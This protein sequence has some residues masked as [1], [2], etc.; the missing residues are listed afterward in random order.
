[1]TELEQLDYVKKYFEPLSNKDVEFVD[2]YLQVLFPA[3][4]GKP[5]DHVVFS[6]DGSG[7]DSNDRHYRLRIRAYSQNA[8]FDTE[9]GNNDGMVTKKE[10]KD[11]VQKY[12]DDG[13]NNRAINFECDGKW[14][15]P[16][17]NGEWNLHT[18]GGA[19]KP[20]TSSFGATRNG[21]ARNHQGFDI[22]AEVGTSLYACLDG[23]IVS[24]SPISGYGITIILKIDNVDDL[25]SAKNEYA[26]TYPGEI[27]NGPG[28]NLDGDIY[29]RYAHSESAT[30][31]VGDSV[32]AGQIIGKSG[33]SG[34]ASGTRAPHLHFEIS[35][36][37]GP[38]R[39]LADRTNPAF[40]GTIKLPSDSNRSYQQEAAQQQHKV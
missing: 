14:V 34:S 39:G 8:G 18:F 29:L 23:T 19:Y 32:K 31:S 22:F 30:V 20:S 17:A 1:M 15:D 4:M 37:L 35:N 11:S 24:T 7:L 9:L 3:S 27:E 13:E 26:L 33:V 12:I 25:K 36:K 6:R 28:F 21:G 40:Y 5:D 10:I 2:F 38:G 16:I